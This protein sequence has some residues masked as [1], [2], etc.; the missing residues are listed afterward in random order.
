M[1][2]SIWNGVQSLQEGSGN[3]RQSDYVQSCISKVEV[4]TK[5]LQKLY[6]KDSSDCQQSGNV[7]SEVSSGAAGGSVRP[8]KAPKHDRG[9][10][11]GP[12]VTSAGP[13]KLLLSQL[14]DRVSAMEHILERDLR[15]LVTNHAQEKLKLG[16]RSK[17]LK[18]LVTGSTVTSEQYRSLNDILLQSFD[19][20]VIM[21]KDSLDRTEDLEQSMRIAVTQLVSGSNG[22][23]EKT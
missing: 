19:S 22:V 4:I 2:L 7:G 9:V 6:T 23:E 1:L 17:T 12:S 18:D 16:Q 20:W 13:F 3:E 21:N 10:T 8:V 11:A 15:A 14:H 5:R